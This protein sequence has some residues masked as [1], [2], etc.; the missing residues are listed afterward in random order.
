[1]T[2]NIPLLVDPGDS[3]NSCANA[4]ASRRSGTVPPSTSVVRDFSATT[5]QF[6][7]LDASACVGCMDCVTQCPDGAI[8]A[9]VVPVSVAEGE[10]ERLGGD[11]QA[12]RSWLVRTT[13]FHDIPARKGQEPGSFAL[14]VDVA[15]C[16]GCGECVTA[17]G[18]HGALRMQPK[19]ETLMGRLRAGFRLVRAL[20]DTPDAYIQTKVLPD[21]MLKASALLYQGGGASCMGCGEATAIRMTLAATGFVYGPKGI[22]VVAATGCNTVFGSTF[23]HNPYQV[24]WTSSLFENAPAV[25][26]GIRARWNA[27]GMQRNRL[28]VFGGDGA[29]FD[30]GLQCLSRMLASGMDIKVLVLDT[31]AYSNTGGQATTSSF[32]AQ[33]GK[34][35]AYGAVLRGKIE[36]RKELAQIAMMHP[37]IYVAQTTCAHTTHFYRTILAANEFPGPA[38]IIA[39]TPCQPE[40]GIA[41]DASVKQAE[42]AVA[43]RAFP[44]LVHDP[45][46]GEKLQERLSLHGNPARKDDWFVTSDGKQFDFIEFARTENR[47]ASQFDGDGNP[48]AELRSAQEDRLRNW[49]QLQELAGLR[50]A[51]ET[52]G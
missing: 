40:H 31:Q 9:K 6:P 18:S 17:C 34:L 37:D 30:I 3:C 42:L 5:R 7:E 27:L 49:R 48:S 21:M 22:G 46:N 36:R 32:R 4:C 26:M 25:A 2:R 38:V 24:P 15:R 44:L 47:F 14:A 10:I 39:Y 50:P 29:M 11:A 23:P 19:D 51:G 52:P 45:R 16:K 12:A 33:E 13:K 1:M 28:W 43:S 8:L 41:D 35:M 20:P